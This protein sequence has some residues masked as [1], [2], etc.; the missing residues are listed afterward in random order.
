M[1]IN[2]PASVTKCFVEHEEASFQTWIHASYARKCFDVYEKKGRCFSPSAQKLQGF[3][4]QQS[5]SHTNEKVKLYYKV[6]TDIYSI[7][8]NSRLHFFAKIMQIYSK[9][10]TGRHK[11]KLQLCNLQNV[12]WI[13]NLRHRHPADKQWYKVKVMIKIKENNRYKFRTDLKRF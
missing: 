6:W 10:Y 12:L 13:I 3:H 9:L 11:R 7:E 5:N 1:N 8:F 2:S 4:P